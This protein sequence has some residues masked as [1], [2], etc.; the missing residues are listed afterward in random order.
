MG[1]TKSQIERKKSAAMT[2]MM[3][4][5]RDLVESIHVSDDALLHV[6]KRLLH[7]TE[8]VEYQEAADK[9]NASSYTSDKL[10]RKNGVR[11][12]TWGYGQ[13]RI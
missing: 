9:A 11:A 4:L 12:D 6:A 13:W 7:K 10:D 3:K 2:S 8:Q 1:K 5:R